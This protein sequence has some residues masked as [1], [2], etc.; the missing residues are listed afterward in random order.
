M[1]INKLD[2]PGASLRDSLHSILSHRLHRNPILISVPVASFDPDIYRRGDPGI[3]GLVDIAKWEVWKWDLDPS[4][5]SQVTRHEL[6][7]SRKELETSSVFP[8]G[9]PMIEQLIKARTEFIDSIALL[10]PD[11][12]SEIVAEDDP[13]AYL[14]ISTQAII[15]NLRALT[16]QKEILPV[17]C[18]SA[19]KH[20]GTELLMNY[21][22]ELLASP[23]DIDVK[24]DRQIAPAKSQLVQLLAW[25]VGWDK[26]KGWM[27]FVRIYSGKPIFLNSYALIRASTRNTLKICQF[28]EYNNREEGTHFKTDASI[29]I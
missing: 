5:S 24:N 22:G 17:F 1:F 6:P 29:C 13:D 21:V 8:T 16:L 27:T 10:S 14:K 26:R 9:H 20:V 18:G 12:L 3:E 7:T 19:L 23:L 2:R 15:S 28:A 25:K 11:L 4:S